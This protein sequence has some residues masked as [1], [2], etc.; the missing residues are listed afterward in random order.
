MGGM[1]HRKLRIAWSV[2]WGVLAVLFIVS[3]VRSFERCDTLGSGRA[4]QIT[5][6]RGKVFLNTDLVFTGGSTFFPS[7]LV[8]RVC[9]YPIE[10]NSIE[11]SRI[12]PAG[13]GHR[14]SH[15]LPALLAVVC[16]TLPW[17]H[18]RFSLRT[19]LIATMLV[20]I[21]LTLIVWPWRR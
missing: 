10:L 2:A 3:W 16:G 14:M 21:I 7:P 6:L 13:N 19:L 20:G 11:A 9:G 18:W 8:W 15:W 4:I 1:K 17:H 5:S 12:H